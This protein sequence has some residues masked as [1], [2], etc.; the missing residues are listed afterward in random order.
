MKIKIDVWNPEKNWAEILFR[1]VIWLLLHLNLRFSLYGVSCLPTWQWNNFQFK[2]EKFKWPFSGDVEKVLVWVVQTAVHQKLPHWYKCQKNKINPIAAVTR[3][4]WNLLQTKG[5]KNRT[6]ENFSLKKTVSI[7]LI[8]KTLFKMTI[9][10]S[11][12]RFTAVLFMIYPVVKAKVTFRPNKKCSCPSFS[13]I[14]F[15]NRVESKAKITFHMCFF[16][17]FFLP[18]QRDFQS[19]NVSLR[20]VP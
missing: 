1:P 9:F 19:Q 5:T 18:F 10:F 8:G 15:E 16:L 20:P 2:S 14:S 4:M 3:V 11:R 13:M 6:F 7:I 17:F 12:D